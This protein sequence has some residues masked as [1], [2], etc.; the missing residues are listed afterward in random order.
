MD[1][2]DWYSDFGSKAEYEGLLRERLSDAF[3]GSERERALM[4]ARGH[5]EQEA[6]ADDEWRLQSDI[7]MSK[8][9]AFETLL[10]R[11]LQRGEVCED[12]VGD[13]LR[14]ILVW[15]YERLN[16]KKGAFTAAC[17][18]ADLTSQIIS[19]KVVN[20]KSVWPW[21]A[22]AIK[23]EGFQNEWS[24][25]RRKSSK[26]FSRP[27]F[28][29]V[30]ER[31]AR[32]DTYINRRLTDSGLLAA[33][34]GEQVLAASEALVKAVNA[35]GFQEGKDTILWAIAQRH[36]DTWNERSADMIKFFGNSWTQ[37][38]RHEPQECVELVM[39]YLR[40]EW[41]K[42]RKE[43][44]HEIKRGKL[45][46]AEVANTIRKCAVRIFEENRLYDHVELSMKRMQHFV[47]KFT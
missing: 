29:C 14:A 5:S 47:R 7:R 33:K 38:K 13:I 45:A 42:F 17:H 27:V 4:R 11:R 35:A 16:E 32:L 44:R 20:P 9:E 15:I 39:P 36:I 25:N 23:S 28:I 21:I 40:S 43:R 12:R 31:L 6:R 26:G 2:P 22:E 41:L 1:L 24:F 18:L 37:M 19:A 3:E 46:P 8:K 10:L 34:T 30:A